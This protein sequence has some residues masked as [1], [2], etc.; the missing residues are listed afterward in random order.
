MNMFSLIMC[1]HIIRPK[2]FITNLASNWMVRTREIFRSF[3]SYMYTK[4]T[5]GMHRNRFSVLIVWTLQHK[6]GK[7]DQTKKF[8]DFSLISGTF[9]KFPAFSLTGKSESLFPGFPQ[10]PCWLGTLFDL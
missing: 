9:P 8:P 6:S 3:L 2:T 5:I 4:A 7:S 1:F 10:F